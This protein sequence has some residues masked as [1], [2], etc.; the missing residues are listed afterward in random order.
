[1]GRNKLFVNVVV[2][3]HT[4]HA[5]QNETS[6]CRHQTIGN[7]HGWMGD[8]RRDQTQIIILWCSML[9]LTNGARSRMAQD[10]HRSVRAA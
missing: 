6:H 7:C 3:S 2:S 1:M 9:G 8:D 5:S 4:R 10:S